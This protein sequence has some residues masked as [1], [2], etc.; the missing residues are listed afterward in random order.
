MAS[1]EAYRYP[2]ADRP[3]AY[4]YLSDVNGNENVNVDSW[5]GEAGGNTGGARTLKGIIIMMLIT[6]A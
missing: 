2:S 3:E 1:P 4:R 5:T 6:L